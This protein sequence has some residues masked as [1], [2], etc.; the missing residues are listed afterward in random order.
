MKLSREKQYLV[1][2]NQGLVHYLVNKFG[3]TKTSSEYEDLVAIGTI[4]LIKAA[5]TFDISRSIKFATYASRCINNEILMHYRK[6]K[7]YAND[8]S[9]YEPIINDYE[10]NEL[11]LE[12]MIGDLESN[13]VEKI[14]NKGEFANLLN[15][16]LNFLKGK[17]RI[18]LLYRMGNLIQK[19]IADK[20][21][22]SQSYVARI[23][24][25]AIKDVKKIA[26][27]QVH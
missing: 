5:I 24:A 1:L 6:A 22:L 14:E 8:I 26:S 12:D 2:D 21:N 18:V 10:G 20:I 19:E 9:I 13:F 15:I 4:G 16:V 17:Y 3:I 11:T 27:Q 25:K 7:L 23:L